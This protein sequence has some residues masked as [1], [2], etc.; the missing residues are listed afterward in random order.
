MASFPGTHP[1]PAAPAG[2]LHVHFS[3]YD[4]VEIE[5]GGLR[6]VKRREA[7]PG[8]LAAA[9]GEEPV[10]GL[11]FD[12]ALEWSAS[13][14]G[15]DPLLAQ[16]GE[17]G[18]FET[19]RDRLRAHWAALAARPRPADRGMIA[20]VTLSPGNYCSVGCA[21]CYAKPRFTGEPTDQ[22]SDET[23]H[24]VF[25]FIREDPRVRAGCAVTIGGGG[26]GLENFGFYRRAV[27]LARQYE[28]DY[29]LKI[30]IYLATVDPLRLLADPGMLDLI[31]ENQQWVT[32]SID[33]DANLPYHRPRVD[34]RPLLAAHRDRCHWSASAVFT[35][36]TAQHIHHNYLYLLDDGFEAIQMIPARLAK[37]H[38]L[39]LEPEHFA[40]A[41][42]QYRELLAHLRQEGR[43]LE[44]FSRL[45]TGDALGRFLYRY[46][47]EK[48]A[49]LRCGAGLQTVFADPL[50]R[51]Y[52]CPSSAHPSTQ[53]GDVDNGLSR[54]QVLDEVRNKP[55]ECLSCRILKA[56]G[57]PCTHE[58]VL[59][60]EVAG[61]VTPAVCD[62][63]RGLCDVVAELMDHFYNED[64]RSLNAVFE[65]FALKAAGLPATP[66]E[67]G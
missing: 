6:L 42:S 21:Y 51:L 13:H 18:K 14:L 57:G 53:L 3:P 31:V 10:D 23:L 30:P 44:L 65:T 2:G 24:R 56:C 27:E 59:L 47:T 36:R 62:F 39:H 33:G 1:S 50:G 41:V 35:A 11:T 63:Q 4:R 52:P 38:L 37:S 28:R 46:L 34:F 25:A 29:G 8:W 55:A 58:S 16:I 5:A 66:G 54:L 20:G 26:D 67:E 19:S 43:L 61:Q 40:V 48:E 17:I 12:Q 64:P 22:T 32:L 49:G 45:T 9:P 7:S 15:D 60:H